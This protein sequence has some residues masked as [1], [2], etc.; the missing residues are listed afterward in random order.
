[1]SKQKISLHNLEIIDY[2]VANGIITHHAALTIA[3]TAS[4]KEK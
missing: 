2:A 3:Q 4:I 1:M